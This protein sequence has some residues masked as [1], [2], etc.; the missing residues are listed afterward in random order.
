VA[1]LSV[2]KALVMRNNQT[3]EASFNDNPSHPLDP[4]IERFGDLMEKLT[5]AYW[6]IIGEM[7]FSQ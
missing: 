2:Y 7:P 4:E 6:N 3:I 1:L 5:I